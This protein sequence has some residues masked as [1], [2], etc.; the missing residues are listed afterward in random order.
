MNAMTRSSLSI[1]G[2]FSELDDDGVRTNRCGPARAR[3]R[4]SAIVQVCMNRSSGDTYHMQHHHHSCMPY[5]SSPFSTQGFIWISI[6]TAMTC[7]VS[8]LLKDHFGVSLDQADINNRRMT[9]L[10]GSQKALKAFRTPSSLAS[11][12]SGEL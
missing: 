11:T 5:A 4:E 1:G 8:L 3:R 12:A 9:S 6:L 10:S 2:T 7:L